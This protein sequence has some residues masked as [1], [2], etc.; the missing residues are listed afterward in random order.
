MSIQIYKSQG[1]KGLLDQ[2]FIEEK[3]SK[4][5]NSL[6]MVSKGIDF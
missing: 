1:K 3:L 5:G 2:Q 6:E 4:I